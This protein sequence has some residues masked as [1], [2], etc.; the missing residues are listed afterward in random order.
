MS[1]S[2]N[3]PLA[4]Y[5]AE[6]EHSPSIDSRLVQRVISQR[7][8]S[9]LPPRLHITI[10]DLGGSHEVGDEP[11][12]PPSPDSEGTSMMMSGN[13][14]LPGL[15]RSSVGSLR[16]RASRSTWSIS[17]PGPVDQGVPLLPLTQQIGDPNATPDAAAQAQWHHRPAVLECPFIDLRCFQRFSH[18]PSWIDHSL[19]H[20][21]V[22]GL[23]VM[24]P[25]HSRCVFCSATFSAESGI[26][27][28]NDKLVCTAQHHVREGAKLEHAQPD[29]AL[30]Q[31]LWEKGCISKAERKELG[32]LRTETLRRGRR[33]M[34]AVRGEAGLSPPN[35]P[36]DKEGENCEQEAVIM[37]TNR[38]RNRDVERRD[39]RIRQLQERLDAQGED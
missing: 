1:V 5:L 29:F 27:S 21:K 37:T 33:G 24:P 26:A 22:G 23:E 36:G 32:Q 4:R 9:Q 20:F 18:F 12:P 11:S 35:S 13:A 2:D 25:T 19:E 10:D 38:G 14:S 15:R 30:H 8:N 17:T 6:R 28:W 31:Y 34:G 16:S 7:S 3:F 39:R